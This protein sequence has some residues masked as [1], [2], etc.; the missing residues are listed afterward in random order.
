MNSTAPKKLAEFAIPFFFN[1]K[2]YKKCVLS[3][4]DK[5]RHLE[6]SLDD[7]VKRIQKINAK[8]LFKIIEMNMKYGPEKTI[9]YVIRSFAS[10][11]SIEINGMELLEGIVRKV[12]NGKYREI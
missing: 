8:E 6:N 7:A 10:T 4:K 1:K 5:N 11:E 3:Y 12:P 2:K 9:E